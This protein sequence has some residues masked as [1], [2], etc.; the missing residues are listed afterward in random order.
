MSK[1]GFKDVIMFL[2]IFGISSLFFISGI[3]ICFIGR[4]YLNINWPE[5]IVI[6]V[7][8]IFSG[9]I[10]SVIETIRYIK[11]HNKN[12]Q[13]DLDKLKRYLDNHGYLSWV[14]EQ[15]KKEKD[16]KNEKDL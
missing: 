4:K 7:V 11:T 8:L 1:L 5:Y 3:V 6:S 10:V 15:E 14:E 16:K 13:N 2:K 9:I 12:V